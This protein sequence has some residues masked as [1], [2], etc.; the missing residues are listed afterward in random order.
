MS[1]PGVPSRAGGSTEGQAEHAG[2]VSRQGGKAEASL[3]PGESCPQRGNKN[4][5]NTSSPQPRG[6]GEAPGTCASVAVWMRAYVWGEHTLMDVCSDMNAWVW[7][8][9]SLCSDVCAHA[10]VCMTHVYTQAKV[11]VRGFMHV[12]TQHVYTTG[13]MCADT[14]A[15]S[16]CVCMNTLM[17]TCR[18]TVCG[19]MCMH[20]RGCG[21]ACLF[22]DA[23]TYI[24][25]HYVG[26]WIL[27]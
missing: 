25:V 24:S 4:T 3:T 11:C 17:C 23:R 6:T 7:V 26:T 8:H 10:R 19:Y 18:C 20:T 1:R 12:C 5:K 2:E 22:V 21:H 15:H 14:C 16:I 27:V 13:C 9:E